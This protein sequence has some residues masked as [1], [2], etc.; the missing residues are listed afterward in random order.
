MIYLFFIYFLIASAQLTNKYILSFLAADFFV[1]LRMTISGLILL[2]FYSNK[3]GVDFVKKNF[4]TLL[5]ISISTTFLP[6]LLR[7]Y[8]FQKIPVS[9]AS[10][11]GALE[12][13]IASLWMYILYNQK[14]NRNQ[15]FGCLL[16]VVASFIFIIMQAKENI[17]GAKIFVLGDF[18]QMA[19]ILISR[20]GWIQ[21]QQ[22]LVRNE[23]TPRQLN[24][25]SFLLSGILSLVM[26]TVRGGTI[27]FLN[28]YINPIFISSLFYTT[29]IGN[30]FAY[31]LYTKA[32]RSTSI[33]Y[34]AVAG[35]STPLFIHVLSYL[36]GFESISHS[37]FISLALLSVALYI[38]QMPLYEIPH[39]NDKPH[40]EGEK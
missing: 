5:L 25:Y 9:R 2:F 22:I 33:T 13:F 14:L 35:L 23:L 38:F 1:F 20:F 12:P 37:F 36:V 4:L 39:D 17:L 26:Y 24:A 6:S 18:A 32:L 31:G 34:I 8:A 28:C 27:G 11:W 30:I 21:S 10:F 40:E 29:L 15:F 16:G 3:E 19:S 7:G